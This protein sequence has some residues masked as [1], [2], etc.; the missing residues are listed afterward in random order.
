MVYPKQSCLLR[1][2]QVVLKQAGL[3]LKGKDITAGHACCDVV[4]L[5]TT[6]RQTEKQAQC[7]QQMGQ[8][9]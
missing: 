7:V 3:F 1:S 6:C 9:G 4:L 2:V 8:G 5:V